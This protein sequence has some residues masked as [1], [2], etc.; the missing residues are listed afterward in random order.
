MLKESLDG[1]DAFL[2]TPYHVMVRFGMWEEILEEPEPAAELLATRAVWRYA[3]GV[4]L[5]SLGRVEEAEKERD[6]FLLAA[7]KVPTSRTLFNNVVTEI[8]RVAVKV[9]EGEIPIRN[10]SHRM[11]DIRTAIRLSEE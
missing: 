3:R 9:L 10:H 7:V 4:A 6:A 5:A 8:L 2:A 1:L 11:D